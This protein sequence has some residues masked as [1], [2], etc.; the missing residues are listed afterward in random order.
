MTKNNEFRFTSSRI[1]ALKPSDKVYFAKDTEVKGLQCK[2][3]PAGNKTFVVYR[4]AKGGPPVRVTLC[5]FNDMGLDDVR[6]QAREV[7]SQLAS[8]LNPNLERKK[9]QLKRKAEQETLAEVL[10]EYIGLGG[11]KDSTKRFYRY[12]IHKHFKDWLNQPIV[13]LNEPQLLRK[14]H[15]Q[16]TNDSGPGAGNNSLRILRALLNYRHDILME[17]GA[18]EDVL[19]KYRWKI[20]RRSKFWN[21]EKERENWINPKQLPAWWEATEALATEF[22]GHGE[23]ARDYLQMLILTGMRRREL[24]G[25]LW[26]DVDLQFG[27]VTVRDT[28]NGDDLTIP[29]SDYVLEILKRRPVQGKRVFAFDETKY[30]VNFVRNRSGVD[31]IIHDLRRSF[32]SYCKTVKTDIYSKKRLVN[33]RQKSDVTQGYIQFDIEELR[34]SIQKV[35]D[36]VLSQTKTNIVPFK[37]Q[38]LRGKL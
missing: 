16:I 27:V 18:G 5:K 21:K 13:D 25:L 20:S 29:C 32:L 14:L 17:S 11:I 36:Y 23:R 35:T 8:G 33:H 6:Q 7:L 28:K 24:T 22:T 9:E 19:M 4:R 37:R 26:K 15:R 2:V 34:L 1:V 3:T 30:F 10:N 38:S 31:F 12:Q